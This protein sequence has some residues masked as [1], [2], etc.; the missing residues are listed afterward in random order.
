MPAA[1]RRRTAHSRQ[2]RRARRSSPMHPTPT[3]LD[4]LRAHVAASGDV[5]KRQ[6]TDG[7][8][9]LVAQA[10]ITDREQRARAWHAAQVA[11]LVSAKTV[12]AWSSKDGWLE[13]RSDFQ[14]R[15]CDDVLK[16]L[17]A[18]HV[19]HYVA[20]LVGLD[21][22]Y[23]RVA[24]TLLG[25]AEAGDREVPTAF[26]SR[27]EAIRCLLLLDARRD[28]KRRLLERHQP[29]VSPSAPATPSAPIP[30]HV[31]RAM[32]HARLLAERGDSLGGS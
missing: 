11:D 21:E 26:G 12:Q 8:R 27:A 4:N 30:P 7:L 22:L 6:W 19:R 18:D 16:Q 20:D 9:A 17:G 13:K 1:R 24:A 2:L 3:A 5:P 14:R 29:A 15:I 31:A 10:F 28:E 23:R 25:V 32:A